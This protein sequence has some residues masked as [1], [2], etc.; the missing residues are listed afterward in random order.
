MD[1][2]Q[3]EVETD[4]ITLAKVLLGIFRPFNPIYLN[5]SK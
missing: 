1:H 2:C 3:E 5:N 4:F